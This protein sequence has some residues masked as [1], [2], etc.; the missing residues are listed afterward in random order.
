MS[1]G[2]RLHMRGIITHHRHGYSTYHGY[3]TVYIQLPD[4][5]GSWY[6]YFFIPQV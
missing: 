2:K 6:Y 3:I 5:S 4:K 1:S